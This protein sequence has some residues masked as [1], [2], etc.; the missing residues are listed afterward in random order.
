MFT[1]KIFDFFCFI[2]N[3]MTFPNKKWGSSAPLWPSSTPHMI[4]CLS[5]QCTLPGFF[6]AFSLHLCFPLCFLISSFSTSVC[7][8]PSFISFPKKTDLWRKQ[9]VNKMIYLFENHSNPTQQLSVC[10]WGPLRVT[11]AWCWLT[12]E[13]CAAGAKYNFLSAIVQN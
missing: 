9:L 13:I 2:N 12:R 10:V 3:K 4:D 7:F 5:L 11:R 6:F 1:V 8:T